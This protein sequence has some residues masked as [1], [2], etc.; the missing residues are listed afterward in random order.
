MDWRGADGE[1]VD[2]QVLD[3]RWIV[4]FLSLVAEAKARMGWI[5]SWGVAAEGLEISV[6]YLTR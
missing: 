5:D 4:D 3:G 2:K 1:T 6:Y